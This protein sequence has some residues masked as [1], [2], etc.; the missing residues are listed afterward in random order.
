MLSMVMF[1]VVIAGGRIGGAGVSLGDVIR[2]GGS[3]LFRSL[4]EDKNMKLE[5]QELRIDAPA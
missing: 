4:V 1:W 3:V 5:M 2:G